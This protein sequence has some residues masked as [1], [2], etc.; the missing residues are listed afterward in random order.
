MCAYFVSSVEF[1]ILFIMYLV[2][3]VIYTYISILQ[4]MSRIMLVSLTCSLLVTDVS[5]YSW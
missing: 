1:M 5:P 2:N 4:S 3:P